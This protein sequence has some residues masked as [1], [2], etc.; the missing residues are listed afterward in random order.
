MMMTLIM[1]TALV[2]KI[3]RAT[4][5]TAAGSKMLKNEAVRMFEKHLSLSCQILYVQREDLSCCD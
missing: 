2:G 4:S 5:T 1:T 3:A